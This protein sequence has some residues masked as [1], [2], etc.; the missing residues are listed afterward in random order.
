MKQCDVGFV[1]SHV[2]STSGGTQRLVGSETASTS[3]TAEEGA[4]ETL[5]SSAFVLY[6]DFDHC[7]HSCDAYV[8][9]A[10]IVPSEPS[11]TFFEFAGVLENLLVP[12][13]ALRIVLS[14]SWVQALGFEPARDS[15]PLA[16]LRA[17][18]VGA[19]FNPEENLE[20]AWRETPR[21]QQ[22]R[23]H[24]ERYGIKRWL[25]IDDMRAG[26]DGYETHLVHCQQG[27][28][29]GDKD[30]QR[31]LA[32]RLLAMCARGALPSNADSHSDGEL[33]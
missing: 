21:G 29:L 13:P 32:E 3:G 18:V 31:V 1:R 25:A 8:T 7:L 33:T 27:V 22:V 19:T 20:R 24:A 9:A 10:G 26:F 6:L 30:V 28:G 23:R 17:R 12:Y 15:L 5:D 4:F 2:L 14:T 16:S 11:A